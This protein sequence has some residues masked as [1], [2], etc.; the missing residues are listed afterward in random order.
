MQWG[1]QVGGHM[2][3]RPATCGNW[4]MR[5]MESWTSRHR[6]KGSAQ[7]HPRCV[8]RITEG[9]RSTGFGSMQMCPG[10][11]NLGKRMAKRAV[12]WP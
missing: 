12:R 1:L 10:H 11:S 5:K 6:C 9:L 3:G 4:S 2:H 7:T 8:R